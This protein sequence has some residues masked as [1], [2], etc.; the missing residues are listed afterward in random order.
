MKNDFVKESGLIH[1]EKTVHVKICFADEKRQSINDMETLIGEAFRDF[2][3]LTRS[4]IMVEVAGNTHFPK[5]IGIAF[6][7]ALGSAIPKTYL[8][9]ETF[10]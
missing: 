8:S 4:A 10:K 3:Y 7:I 5:Q 2:P 9:T 1:G 6:D